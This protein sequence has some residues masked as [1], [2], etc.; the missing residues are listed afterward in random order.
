MH[1]DPGLVLPLFAALAPDPAT[2][3]GYGE[4]CFNQSGWSAVTPLNA[5]K[6]PTDGVLLLQTSSV[7]A[8]D[9]ATIELTVTLDG[10]PIAGAVEGTSAFGVLAWRP[11]E[12]WAAG[13]THHVSAS[14]PGIEVIE[15]NYYDCP[16]VTIDLDLDIFIDEGPSE[17]LVE[18]ALDVAEQAHIDPIVS[19]DSLACC[20][21]AQ[22]PTQGLG[23]CGAGY[24]TYF[25]PM[26]C[27]PT[28]GH[29]Y[30]DLT[31][32]AGP[33][34]GG[35][36]AKLVSYQLFADGGAASNPSFVPSFTLVRDAPTCV[37]VVATN[38]ATGATSKT[39]EQCFG[40]AIA[41]QLGAQELDPAEALN[42]PLET[43]TVVGD[44]WD[45][46]ACVPF[47]SG[48][49][50]S[51]SGG[52]ETGT[53]AATATAGETDGDGKLDGCAC[54]ARGAGP[55]GL[56]LSVLALLAARRRRR[57]GR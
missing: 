29:G 19:L 18:P 43:C 49:T 39:K 52:S 38:L 33:A 16:E 51:G 20:V 21:D 8:P 30:L 25:D 26:Q 6:I 15:F 24:Y 48:E 28:K 3:P 4:P 17:A 1:L 41:D 22:P 34:A 45:P 27:A 57:T 42:C 56:G 40:A 44:T 47:P 46:N 50:G 13:A 53:D 35:A 9:P 12:P 11:S 54:D 5:D 36:T 31:A 37:S 32:M 2:C 23:G 55:P 10:Q 14:I 7:G